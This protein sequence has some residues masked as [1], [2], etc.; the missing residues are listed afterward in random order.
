MKKLILAVSLAVVSFQAAA[1]TPQVKLI[2][3]IYQKQSY[4]QYA[5]PEFKKILKDAQRVAQRVDPD[6][7]C[8]MA[9]HYDLGFGQDS[10]S[11][12]RYMKTLKVQPIKGN[13]YRATFMDMGNKSSANIELSC[14]N[15]RCQ[16]NNVGNAKENA[17][18]II[19]TK[20][21]GY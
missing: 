3:Q 18:N 5:T 2:K 9:E 10:D 1:E 8:E 17:L 14:Q 20:S 16:V 13:V 4:S 11:P 6:M 21:C 15:G 19:R 12:N 7:G